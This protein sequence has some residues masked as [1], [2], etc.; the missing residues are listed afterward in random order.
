MVGTGKEREAL[1]AEAQR[2][3]LSEHIV[4]AGALNDNELHSLY[5]EVDL[6]VHPTLY[7]GSSLVTLEAMIYRLPVVAS[8][9]GGIPDKVFP[10][11]NGLL[12]PPGN[13]QALKAALR[14]ALHQRAMWSSWGAHGR[15]IVETTFNWPT[16]AQ[17]TRA[18][19]QRM[20]DVASSTRTGS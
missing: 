8:A 11:H 6:F 1:E 19:Y 20:L 10:Q 14:E 7:E 9:A 15:T 5:E 16:V 12:V 2:L 3:G 17:R 13:A 4:F 18:E